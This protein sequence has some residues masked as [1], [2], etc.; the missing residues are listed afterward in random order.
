MI[1]VARRYRFTATHSLPGVPGYD[2]EHEHLY[3]VE[4]V[5]SADLPAGG[6]PPGMVVD[7]AEIDRVLEP[8]VEA[9]RGTSLD[10][11]FTVP[12]TVENIA[13]ALLVLVSSSVPQVSSVRV[14]EDE[15]RWGA[16]SR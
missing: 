13:N 14:W 10:D 7:T 8:H 4:V 5:A 12:T 6:D 16:A 1:E 3:T 11:A 9:W 2:E 15:D